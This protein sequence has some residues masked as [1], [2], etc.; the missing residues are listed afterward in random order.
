[1]IFSYRLLLLPIAFLLPFHALCIENNAIPTSNTDVFV[2]SH[3]FGEG[4]ERNL[5]Y[6]YWQTI[7]QGKPSL[8][9][10]IYPDA[11]AQFRKACFYTKPAVITLAQELKKQVIEQ[12]KSRIHLFGRS[13]GASTAINCLALLSNYKDYT[14]YFQNSDITSEDAQQIMQAI[15]SG[16]LFVHVPFLGLHKARVVS[17]LGAGLRLSTLPLAFLAVSSLGTEKF[18]ACAASILTYMIIGPQIQKTYN[19]KL[20]PQ[21]V[22]IIS[23]NHFDPVHASPLESVEQLKGKLSCPVLIHVYAHDG[24]VDNPDADTTKIY[25]CMKEG[26]DKVHMYVS[27]T[28]SHNDDSDEAIGIMQDF[29]QK[30]NLVI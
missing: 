26:N 29:V 5:G 17:R 3:G 2:F 24:I 1:V 13:C 18:F 23:N 28:G 15:N 14:A 9:I 21:M 16:S 20:V 22:R 8:A 4:I 10:P 6:A 7:F 30:Y 27:K 19:T 25:T 12:Q 11:P